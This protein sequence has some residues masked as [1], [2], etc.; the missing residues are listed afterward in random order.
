MDAHYMS[1]DEND[2]CRA[3]DKYTAWLDAQL[4]SVDHSVDQNQKKVS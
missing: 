4:Q 2:L 1:L 3:M